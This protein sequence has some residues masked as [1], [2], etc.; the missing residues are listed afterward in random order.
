MFADVLI[1]KLFYSWRR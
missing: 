1:F